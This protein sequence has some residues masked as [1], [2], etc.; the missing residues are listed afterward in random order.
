MK[1][2]LG[3]A[4]VDVREDSLRQRRRVSEFRAREHVG[5]AGWAQTSA[6]EAMIRA[7]REGLAATDALRQ[8]VHL[9]T[10]QLRTLPLNAS[11]PER[12]A[13]SEALGDILQ[14][15]QAQ[16]TA[17]QAMD[18][19]VSEALD[20]VAHTPVDD[21]SVARLKAIHGRVREQVATLETIIQSAQVQARTLDQIGELDRVSAEF[22]DRVVGLKRLSEQEQVQTLAEEGEHVVE[23][24]GALD[25]AAPQQVD[26][27]SR[28]GEAVAEEMTGTGASPETQ[29]QALEE[30]A[31]LMAEKAQGVRQD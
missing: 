28:I 9:T 6:L 30:L 24:I 16:F 11:G 3:S 2:T 21:L 8:V 31:H 14:S 23:L 29:A 27:L 15:S 18:V 20:A 26:A 7:G 12:S 22:H 10:E 4:L 13:Q 1:E 5:A 19:L 17:A 25:G